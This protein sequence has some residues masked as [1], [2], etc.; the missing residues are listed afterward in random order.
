M[1]NKKKKSD[2][3]SQVWYFLREIRKHLFFFYNKQ[4]FSKKETF[5]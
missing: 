1:A 2:F 5:Y 4:D 3:K